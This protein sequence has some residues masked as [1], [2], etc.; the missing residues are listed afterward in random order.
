MKVLGYGMYGTVYQIVYRGKKCAMKIEHILES[1]IK[2]NIHSPVWRE[3]DFAKKLGN[4]YPDFFL[5][6][7]NYEII[8]SCSHKQKF[9]YNITLFSPEKRKKIIDTN[10]SPYCIKKVYSLVDYSLDKII[11]KLSIKQLYSMLIQVSYAVYLLHKYKY[12]HGDLHAGNIGVSRT[13]QKFI[14]IGEKKV[15]T[16]GFKY[17]IIDY[18]TILHR[19]YKLDGEEKKNYEYYL[20]NEYRVIRNL[21]FEDKFY[22]YLQKKSINVFSIND[23]FKNSDENAKL[24]EIIDD[25]DDRKFLFKLMFP[26]KYQLIAMGLNNFK[27]VIKPKLLIPIKD[28][29]YLVK[30]GNNF[31]KVLNYFCDKLSIG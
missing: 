6:L 22:Q 31:K 11:H 19:R 8:E 15:P 10:K 5:K 13:K 28:I 1:D 24:K 29:I 4:K 21:I 9:S 18:G 16:F 30:L 2:K 25:F 27:R 23:D 3:I 20:K 26:E 14:K 7:H 17:K 12:T